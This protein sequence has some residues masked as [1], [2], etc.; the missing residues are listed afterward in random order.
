M[1]KNSLGVS[2][3]NA[4]TEQTNPSPFNGRKKTFQKDFLDI[5]N[6]VRSV[7]RAEG[8]PDCFRKAHFHCDQLNCFWRPYCLRE[9]GSRP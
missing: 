6:L 4:Y 3:E 1:E 8:N 5:T 2:E 7:Q 9:E